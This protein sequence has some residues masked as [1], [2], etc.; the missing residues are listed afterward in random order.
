MRELW[1]GEVTSFEGEFYTVEKRPPPPPSPTSRSR[2]WSQ[3]GPRAAELAGR[4]GDGFIGTAPEWE[5]LTAFDGARGKKRRAS[6]RLGELALGLAADALQSRRV[7]IVQ[8]DLLEAQRAEQRSSAVDERCGTLLRR[9]SPASAPGYESSLGW[10]M[11]SHATFP[12]G[13]VRT[14]TRSHSWLASHRP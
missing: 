8:H 13:N 2:S 14:W 3:L 1:K 4:L 11:C 9:R 5:L 7:E 10:C 6:A 12:V